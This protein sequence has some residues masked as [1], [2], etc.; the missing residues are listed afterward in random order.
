MSNPCKLVVF[1]LPDDTEGRDL[2]RVF[3]KFGDVVECN[4]R[5]IRAG[6]TMGFLEFKD[7]R[8]AQDAVRDRHG[9]D[10]KGRSIRVEIAGAN[11]GRGRKGD[12]GDSR[13][14]GGRGDSRRRGGYSR[15]DSRRRDSRRRG[16]SGKGKGKGKGKPKQEDFSCI[17][18]NDLP[19]GASWQDI[20]DFSRP[21]GDV[22]YSDVK[23]DYG[24]AGFTSQ[25]DAEKAV[26]QLDGQN[27]KTFRGEEGKV[28]VELLDGKR[29]KSTR[30]SR[31]RSAGSPPRR[32]NRS[33]GG[34]RSNSRSRSRR[35]RSRSRRSDRSN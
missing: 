21:A 11:K 3:D 18:I 5:T 6:N 31:S 26:D 1:N 27:F 4:V 8:D 7:E 13:R 22:R 30:R 15:R 14:R 2:E 16:R 19:S 33:S 23:G 20:K 28:S 29:G 10:M 9:Y 35:S 32:D 34:K 25:S 17:R 12:R 24:V